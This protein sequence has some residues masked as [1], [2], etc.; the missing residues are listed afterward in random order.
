MND[1]DISNH[2]FY[3]EEEDEYYYVGYPDDPT[4]NWTGP[5]LVDP[6]DWVVDDEIP[7]DINDLEELFE[8]IDPDKNKDSDTLQNDIKNFLQ[9]KGIEDILRDKGIE[10]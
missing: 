5:D 2:I 10:Y 1:D 9:K 7:F 3:D 6:W 4:N 8:I